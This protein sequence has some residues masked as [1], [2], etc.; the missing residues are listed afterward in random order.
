MPPFTSKDDAG[1]A[2]RLPLIVALMGLCLSSLAAWV[3]F[4]NAEQRAH[5]M[6]QHHVEI[7]GRQLDRDLGLQPSLP[8]AEPDAEQLLASLQLLD[9]DVQLLDLQLHKIGPEN[10]GAAAHHVRP[11]RP[12]PHSHLASAR[13]QAMQSWITLGQRWQ[14]DA[15][16]TPALEASQDLYLVPALALSLGSLSSL[17]VAALLRQQ[18]VSRHRAEQLA[19]EMTADLSRLALV[20][21]ETANAVVITDAKRRITWVNA[22]F[23]RLTG[24]TAEEAM[25]QSPGALLQFSGTDPMTVRQMRQAFS[26]GKAFKGD[27]LNQDKFGRAYWLHLDVQPVHGDEGQLTGFIAIESDI[28]SRKEAEQATRA[29]RAFL[30]QTGRIGGIGGW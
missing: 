23:E 30:D 1:F 2:T 4:H 18:T 13:F 22:G 6:F 17:L 11:A 3:V 28:T 16:S 21:R 5:Q 19:A 9:P 29:A 8:G 24:Y 7:L 10:S 15:R 26:K 20:V 25:G 14:L 12:A 27:V